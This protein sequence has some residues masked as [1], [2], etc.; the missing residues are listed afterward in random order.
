MY[1]G[2]SVATMKSPISLAA[3]PALA[4]A[5]TP[6]FLWQNRLQFRLYPQ[7]GNMPLYNSILLSVLAVS[8]SIFARFFNYSWFSD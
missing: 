6:A 3:K 2:V 5:S 7:M 8:K 4:I 1:S